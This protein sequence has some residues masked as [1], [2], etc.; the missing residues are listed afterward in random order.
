MTFSAAS[1]IM[2]ANG[3]STYQQHACLLS[4]KQGSQCAPISTPNSD[5]AILVHTLNSESSITL[6]SIFLQSKE[7]EELELLVFPQLPLVK[8]CFSVFK[9]P[10]ITTCEHT[11]CP[12]HDLKS[13]KCLVGKAHKW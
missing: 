11:F 9:D 8:L 1:A 12:R 7:E 4:T 3:T 10:G 2:K 5:L 6:C 13:E